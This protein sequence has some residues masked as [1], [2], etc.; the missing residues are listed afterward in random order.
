[1]PNYPRE[2]TVCFTGHRPKA[3]APNPYSNDAKPIYQNIV[4][5]IYNHIEMLYLQYGYRRF[6]SGGAQ[7]F[8]Q[9]AFW[10][11]DRL[12]Q[13]YPDVQNSVYI[14]FIGQESRWSK[15]GIFSQAE[16]KNMLRH[17]DDTYV[18]KDNVDCSNYKDVVIALDDRNHCM[19]NDSGRIVG[20]FEDESWRLPSTKSGTA[21][22]LRYAT[23]KHNIIIDVKDF[24]K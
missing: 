12:K 18:C 20:Q 13:K 23:R 5:N 15:Y 10:A 19:V 22:C 3:L 7:G 17:A 2:L 24:T 9:L 14:P 21:N 1:M 11:V 4:N 16:Y 6:I 8:D